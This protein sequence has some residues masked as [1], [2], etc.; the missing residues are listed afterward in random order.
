MLISRFSSHPFTVALF[1]MTVGNFFVFFF[2]IVN[3]NL[4]EPA[5]DEEDGSDKP[6][7]KR[8]L[9]KAPAKGGHRKTNIEVKD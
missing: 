6:K 9:S 1:L 4:I 8:V 2:S 3:G 7:R 5:L